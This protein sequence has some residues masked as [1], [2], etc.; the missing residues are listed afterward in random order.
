MALPLLPI[1]AGAALLLLLSQKKPSSYSQAPSDGSKPPAREAAP[2]SKTWREMPAALQEQVAAALGQLGVSPATGELG[3]GPVSADA[4]KVAT[5]TAALCESQGFYD[6]AKQLR[7]YAAQAAAK[8]PTTPAAQA[9]QQALPPGL[10]EAQRTAIARTLDMDRD[11]KIIRALITTLEALPPS[12]ERDHFLDLARALVLQLEAAQSTTQT[13]QQIDQVI[14]SPGIAEVHTAVQPLPPAIIPVLTPPAPAAAP[15]IVKSPG[16]PPIPSLPAP[17]PPPVIVPAAS[18]PV[19]PSA[20]PPP[21]PASS[22]AAE[23]A[24]EMDALSYAALVALTGSRVLKLTAPVMKGTDVQAWQTVLRKDGY[25]STVKPDQVFGPA[26]LSATKKWQT[27]RGLVADGQVGPATRGKIGTSPAAPAAA[28]PTSPALTPA[29]LPQATAPASAP[30]LVFANVIDP[31]PNAA[32][33][34][35]GMKG[36]AVKSWQN[37]LYALGYGGIVGT[38]DGDFGGKTDSATRALQTYAAQHYR[39]SKPITVDGTVGPQTRRIVLARTAEL[40][41]TVIAGERRVA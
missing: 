11:P 25:A 15:V 24:A 14:K 36:D 1:A 5:Q 28:Q 10:T 34:K 3:D 40:K 37:I 21:P 2:A 8:V 13:L 22:A 38:I 33:L 35:K 41:G 20:A 31:T 17:A 6:V 4:I 9:M 16:L 32:A 19:A 7:D 18:V 29:P 26:T 39:D 30:R 12:A 27:A 23:T